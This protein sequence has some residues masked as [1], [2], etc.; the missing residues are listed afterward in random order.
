M[1]KVLALCLII[2]ITITQTSCMKKK[3]TE[4]LAEIGLVVGIAIDKGN[5]P[6]TTMVTIQVLLPAK[7]RGQVGVTQ[8]QG[9]PYWSTYAYGSTLMDAIRNIS[10]ATSRRLYWGHN[11]MI[12]INDEYAKEG[13]TG[14][15]DFFSRNF[16]LRPHTALVVTSNAASEVLTTQTGLEDVPADAINKLFSSSSFHFM[17]EK[18][19][20]STLLSDFL[21]EAKEPSLA[22]VRIVENTKLKEESIAKEGSNEKTSKKQTELDDIAAFKGDKMVGWL[23]DDESKGFALLTNK[24]QNG[25]IYLSDFKGTGKSISLELTTDELDINPYIQNSKIRFDI[26]LKVSGKI[27]EAG[28]TTIQPIEEFLPQM[29]KEVEAKVSYYIQSLL[30]KIQSDLK[31]DIVGFG[32]KFYSVYPSEW[33]IIGKDW[34]ETFPEIPIK[35]NVKVTIKNSY[36]TTEFLNTK[37]ERR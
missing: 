7:L 21:S 16:E 37:E 30:K 26:K 3:V 6:G 12:V 11:Q 27:V 2:L 9:T 18:S 36:L 35:L 14:V 20:I 1:K 33:S 4:G 13:V 10:K 19:T 25:I 22:G 5:D 17:P 31:T 8:G 32:E 34:S 24:K 29:N 28:L 15:I 23:G